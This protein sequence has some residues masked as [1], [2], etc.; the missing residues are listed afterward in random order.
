M[1]RHW[2]WPVVALGLL[3]IAHPVVVAVLGILFWIAVAGAVVF[4]VRAVRR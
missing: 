4:V 3:A 1:I 2:G